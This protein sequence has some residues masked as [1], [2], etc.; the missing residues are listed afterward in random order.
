MGNVS[1]FVFNQLF[2]TCQQLITT[3][4]IL[5]ANMQDTDRLFPPGKVFWAIRDGSLHP[6]HQRY[7]A[8]APSAS[9]SGQSP[10]LF[11]VLNVEKVFSQI[12]L[13]EMETLI[14]YVKCSNEC[15]LTNFSN[16]G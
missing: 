1:H 10:R 7:H 16:E 11:E 14:P 4:K 6:C 13:T 9:G 3:Q 12:D 2:I 5:E 15:R 8:T